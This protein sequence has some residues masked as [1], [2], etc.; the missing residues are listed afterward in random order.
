[1]RKKWQS[2][3]NANSNITAYTHE[4]IMGLFI[5]QAFN[6]E[7]ANHVEY[8]RLNKHMTGI[9]MNLVLT[10]TLMGPTVEIINTTCMIAIYLIGYKLIVA[11]HISPGEL[12]S[13][14]LY[15]PM[16]WAPINNIINIINNIIT[17]MSNIEKVFETLD[18]E[19]DIDENLDCP[20]LTTIEGDILFDNVTFDYGDGHTVLENVNLHIKKGSTIALV[21]PTGAGKTTVVNLIPRFYDPTGGR[22]LIDGTDIRT[23]NLHSLRKQIGVMMQDSFI[24]SG[25]VMDNIRYGREDATDE[26]CINAAKAVFAHGFIS[27]MRDG[28]NTVL[29]ERGSDLS[30]GEKQLISFARTI[31]INPRILILDEATANIDTDTERLIQQALAKLLEGRTSFVIAHRLSTI[32]K[33]DNI[34][35]IANRGVAESGTHD[36]LIA[37]K[38]K[39][40]ELC[41]NL[42]QSL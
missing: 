27:K 3:R 8:R 39:Y 30:A 20:E 35:Y 2:F 10:M 19:P 22:V 41:N 9:W 24:F 23:V 26:E 15:I 12:F 38:G 21:G 16:F 32:R 42:N 34:L 1:M 7:K 37:A 25:T 40:Y 4:N 36:E 11:N 28:Y 13:F 18:S 31:L 33:A 5:T 29:G 6:R 17:A 14:I